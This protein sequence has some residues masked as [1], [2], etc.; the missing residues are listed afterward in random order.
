MRLFL[1]VFIVLFIVACGATP[2]QAPKQTITTVSTEKAAELVK[3]SQ[4]YLLQAKNTNN[5][6]D[7]RSFLILSLREAVS[8]QRPDSYINTIINAIDI[9]KFNSVGLDIQLAKGLLFAS[10]V[11]DAEAVLERLQQGAPSTQY[12]LQLRIVTAQLKSLNNQS[13]EVIQDVFRLQSLY[14]DKLNQADTT[15]LYQLLWDN[16]REVPVSTLKTFQYDFGASAQ[17]WV[18]LADVIDRYLSDAITLPSELQR[19]KNLYPSEIKSQWLPAQMQKL[20]NVSPYKPQRIALLLPMTGKL[21]K[22]AE[23]V[24]DGFLARLNFNNDVVITVLDTV[25]L[26]VTEIETEVVNNDIQFIVGPL[27]KDT[28]NKLQNS[29][30]LN[31]TPRLNLNIPEVM[32]VRSGLEESKH[33]LTYYY[34]LAPE[35]EIEQAIEYFLGLGVKKP[36]VIYANNTLGRRLYERFNQVWSVATEETVE[37]I[38]FSN[39]SKLGQAVKDLLDVSASEARIKEMKALFGN[40]LE[41]EARSRTDIDA[42]YVIANSQQTRLIK[43]FFDV[44]ISAFGNRLP[45]YASSRS[46]LVDET[47]SQ[48]RDLNGLV[49]TEMPWLVKNTEPSLHQLYD[50]I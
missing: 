42:V 46:Y 16:I 3:D 49:F 32:P 43:P 13:L 31:S 37:A 7:V 44:S 39:R 18:S 27:Q 15:L 24:R 14:T 26:S 10:R 2:T 40:Q 8:E 21:A 9:D 50:K 20:L 30:I 19:W 45:I 28:I 35:D 36:A 29:E 47:Q 38:A 22:Q 25:R 6:T 41:V 34:S 4:Y 23:A 1:I 5:P 33:E 48:K 17:A 11:D 12:D